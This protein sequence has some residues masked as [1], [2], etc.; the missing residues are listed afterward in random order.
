MSKVQAV[1]VPEGSFLREA[2][3]QDGIYTDCFAVRIDADIAFADYI[4]AFYTTPLFRAERLILRAF[5][6]AVSTDAQAR[7]LGEG[8]LDRFAVWRVEARS[9]TQLLMREG[10]TSSWFMLVPPG[11]GQ[12]PDTVLLF[13]SVVRPATGRGG[14]RRM[15][16]LFKAL[17]GA[18]KLYSRLLLAAA[19]RRL[20]RASN[21]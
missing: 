6:R 8:R 10:R 12:G 7:A 2:G 11:T 19:R 20:L 21:P 5:V 16:I 1:A 17:L 15:G 9:D 13:G 4:E 14:K 18:H 3:R